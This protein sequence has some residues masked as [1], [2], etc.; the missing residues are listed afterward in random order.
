MGRGIGF[1]F[2]GLHQVRRR[3]TYTYWPVQTEFCENILQEF[4][5]LHVMK[6]GSGA[7]KPRRT[8]GREF[9]K[10]RQM[11]GNEGIFC[12]PDY[13]MDGDDVERWRTD[14]EARFMATVKLFALQKQHAEKDEKVGQAEELTNPRS[15]TAAQEKHNRDD[16]IILQDEETVQDEVFRKYRP[17][18]FDDTINIYAQLT[19]S[20]FPRVRAECLLCMAAMWEGLNP[21]ADAAELQVEGTMELL[22]LDAD[23]PFI[24]VTIN[25]IQKR[26]TI[27]ADAKLKDDKRIQEIKE[28][29]EARD[30]KRKRGDSGSS[31][32]EDTGNPMRQK[33][34]EGYYSKE[35]EA[36][37]DEESSEEEPMM[38]S[39]K[40][41]M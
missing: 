27:I 21:G 36:I 39:S 18:Q 10:S 22:L 28:R 19:K 20:K 4:F 7:L 2:S 33:A 5:W 25:D 9:K 17:Y 14:Q 3:S 37:E 1:T 26:V 38:L 31:G 6:F 29:N 32:E 12:E 30:A 34:D 41:P 15:K 16:S 40:R 13:P 11:Y 8:M 24:Q 23:D 35:P